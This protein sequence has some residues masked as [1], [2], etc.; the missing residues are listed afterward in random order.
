MNLNL[1]S[2]G[3]ILILVVAV[4]FTV[5][6]KRGHGFP[7]GSLPGRAWVEKLLNP[8]DAVSDDP[9]ELGATT[10]VGGARTA[11]KILYAPLY[12]YFQCDPITRGFMMAN[13]AGIHS[14]IVARANELGENE[15]RRRGATWM[16]IKGITMNYPIVIGPN[17]AKVSFAPFTGSP[18]PPDDSP[19][20]PGEWPPEPQHPFSPASSP[21]PEQPAVWSAGTIPPRQRAP[22]PERSVVVQ[23]LVAGN[24][25]EATI[26]L[27]DGVTDFQVGRDSS[28]GLVLPALP[29]ISARHLLF[30]FEAGQHYATDTSTH[31]SW[32]ESECGWKPLAAGQ[33]TPVPAGSRLLLDADQQVV[34]SLTDGAR[35]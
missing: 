26:R 27:L 15:A 24:A 12:L 6:Y 25:Q 16:P 33:K 17:A 21:A 4:A 18:F 11:N 20:P 3:V 2:G 23:A 31:G 13:P 19:I 29:G 1:Q 10:V 28:C 7:T 9:V 34:L 14:Q 8:T 5:L 30:T 32:I 22:K 35:K